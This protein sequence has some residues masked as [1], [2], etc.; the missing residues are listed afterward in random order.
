MVVL[1]L[2]SHA[3]MTGRE[4]PSRARTWFQTVTSL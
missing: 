2:V 4:S 1:V 3:A